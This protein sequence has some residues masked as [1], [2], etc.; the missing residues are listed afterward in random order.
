MSSLYSFIS[1]AAMMG[2]WVAGLF[3][4]RFWSKTRDPLFK[5]F[6]IAFWL[7]AVERIALIFLVSPTHEDQSKVFLLRLAAFALIL[8]A[9]V[10]KNRADLQ[11][12]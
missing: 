11:R 5:Y 10:N 1:G 9:I 6:G 2:A 3:F 7:L 4:F 8:W 12:S